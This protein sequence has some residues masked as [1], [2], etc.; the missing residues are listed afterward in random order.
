[1]TGC[2]AVTYIS[3]STMYKIAYTEYNMVYTCHIMGNFHAMSYGLVAMSYGHVIDRFSAY[4]LYEL[5]HGVL[6]R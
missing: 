5:R 1:M 3:T 4:P 2:S 6:A